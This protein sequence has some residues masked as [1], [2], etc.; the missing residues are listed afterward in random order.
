VGG[1]KLRSV[2]STRS[3]SAWSCAIRQNCTRNSR[4]AFERRFWTAD[5][6]AIGEPRM[7]RPREAGG[8]VAFAIAFAILADAAITVSD[9]LMTLCLN[10][11]GGVY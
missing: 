3:S 10:R 5:I 2:A 8:A 7:T 9:P 1:A 4:S 6:D 11:E